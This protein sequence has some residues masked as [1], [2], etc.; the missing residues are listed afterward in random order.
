MH[1]AI[2]LSD[3]KVLIICATLTIVFWHPRLGFWW[4]LVVIRRWVKW[5]LMLNFVTEVTLNTLSASF[6][7]LTKPATVR[8]YLL[9]ISYG[10]T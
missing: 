2:L 8:Q 4:R 7:P 6:K 3:D 9:Y 1:E 10:V 5:A